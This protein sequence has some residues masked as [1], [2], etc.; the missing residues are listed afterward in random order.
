M[1]EEALPDIDL[2]LVTYHSERWLDGFFTSLAGQSFPLDK[3]H[4]RVVDHSPDD[5][6]IE[7]V[8]RIVLPFSTGGEGLQFA[9]I[10]IE[11]Q[12]NRGFGAGHNRALAGGTSPF[13]LVSNVDLTFETDTLTRLV[14]HAQADHEH[15]VAWECRQKPYEHP[16]FYDILTHETRWVSGACVLLRRAAWTDTGGFDEH[17]FMYGEDVDLSF[18][19]RNRGGILRYCPDCVVWHHAYGEPG[20]I[21]EAQYF[22]ATLAN[23]YLRLRFG[24]IRDIL[25]GAI[26]QAGLLVH[27]APF[28]GRL[29]RQVCNYA[30]LVRN[31]G[32]FV[33]SRQSNEGMGR[34]PSFR[35]WDYTPHRA[36]A[37]A[38]AAAI[39]DPAPLVSIVVRTYPGRLALLRE[40]LQAL[41]SQTW[42][43]LEV[44]VVEDGGETSRDYV[45]QF[46]AHSTLRVV[47]RAAPKQGRCHA[48]N[49]GLALSQGVFAGFLDDDDLLYADHVEMLANALL[50]HPDRP[51]AFAHAL[52]VETLF[53]PGHWTPYTEATPRS[54]MKRCFDRQALWAANY[55][56][57]QAV[58][59]RHSLYETQGGFCEEL[60]ALEDWDL[61]QRY[62][63][64]GD[65][66]Y[67]DK[68]TSL[69]RTPAN[70]GLRPERMLALARH[71]RVAAERQTTMIYRGKTIPQLRAEAGVTDPFSVT[72]T[73]RFLAKYLVRYKWAY[74][75]ARFLLGLI[76]G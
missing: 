60:D 76:R 27:P 35:K 41:E 71:Y 59:F 32:Y 17:F 43:P 21:K 51:A 22:G 69:Y 1:T 18:R 53:T 55:I 57:I 9:S 15:A 74:A 46:A 25:I 61:W 44:I 20:H 11:R 37:F 19:L 29:R 75:M 54:R 31:A 72:P 23:M 62:A 63:L 13:V 42:R 10:A 58:L 2:S 39:P 40:A 4:L 45:T 64:D 34:R 36:G 12:P 49:L 67:V 68:T 48:G 7:A 8:R 24:G 73:G 66:L 50:A 28:A 47:Y 52:E 26:M 65:F 3:I 6:C 5:A 70:A 14:A 16:K 38:V 30:A 33:H 56:P